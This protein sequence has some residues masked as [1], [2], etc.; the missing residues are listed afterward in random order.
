MIDWNANREFLIADKERRQAIADLRE[1]LSDLVQETSRTLDTIVMAEKIEDIR[2][3]A[4]AGA[5]VRAK[6]L[7]GE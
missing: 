3:G 2:W 4:T 1:A 7:L 5:L 6:R